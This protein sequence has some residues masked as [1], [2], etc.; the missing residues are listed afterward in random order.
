MSR[1]IAGLERRDTSF[2]AQIG[3]RCVARDPVLKDKRNVREDL[4][5]SQSLD[6]VLMTRDDILFPPGTLYTGTSSLIAA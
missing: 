3:Q 2:R 6:N 4:G 1:G 5:L